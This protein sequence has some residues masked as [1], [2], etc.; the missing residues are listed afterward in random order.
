MNCGSRT[1]LRKL[2]PAADL[3]ELLAQGMRRADDDC[4]ERLHACVLALTV[5]SRAILS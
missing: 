2:H 4:L 5:V 3:V 1:P